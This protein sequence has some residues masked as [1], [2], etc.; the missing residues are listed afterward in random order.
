[1]R[2]QTAIA[3]DLIKK[4]KRDFKYDLRAEEKKEI[5][6]KVKNIMGSTNFRVLYKEFYDWLDNPG[7][8]KYA[9]GSGFS[10]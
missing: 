10:P 8:F 9:K 3:T 1:M 6:S 5:R 2:R 7:M 4:A